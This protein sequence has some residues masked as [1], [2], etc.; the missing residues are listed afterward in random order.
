MAQHPDNFDSQGPETFLR[1]LVNAA[2][3]LQCKATGL[4]VI[5]TLSVAAVVSG[6]LLRTSEKFAREQRGSQMV[7]MASMLA[8]AAAP[9]FAA[10]DFAALRDLAAESA[11]GMPLLYVVISDLDGR[12]I[13][14][15]EDEKAG[16]LQTLSGPVA[17]RAPVPGR[18]ILR[19]GSKNVPVF[20]DVTY[21]ITT[22]ETS[23]ATVGGADRA[24]PTKLLGY[25]RTG[26]VE[27]RWQRTMASRLDLLIGVGILAAVVAIPLGFLLVRRIVSPL[28]GLADAMNRFSRGELDVRSSVTRTDEIGR[29]ALAFNR[30]ADEHQRTH[31][32]IVR[33]NADLEKRVAERTEQLRELA[34]REP[35][36]GLYNRRYFN[37]MLEH[38][39]SEAKR[40]ESDISCIMLDLDDFKNVNDRFG[41]QTGD[42]LLILTAETITR[43]LRTA[44]VAARFGGDEFIVLLPQTDSDRAHVL[45][46][47]IA[48]QLVEQVREHLAG[49]RVTVSMGIASLPSANIKNAEALIRAAD[50]A[51][52]EA[53]AAGKDRIVMASTA[54]R[55]AVS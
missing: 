35:L 22:H 17:G 8:K 31:E 49:V 20:L 46:E 19:S 32:R 26:M 28:D 14:A 37:E 11:D 6:Y 10:G 55:P 43:Q 29:L 41:H 53:K 9:V 42:K 44:D 50:N 34:S 54:A 18:P 33:L 23:G 5:L 48:E 13:A 51:L 21:P 39:F 47:R 12:Q 3:S 7:Q 15:A 2:L 36:T 40:Y 16:V 25:V 4:V 45:S 52:Y 27:D 24:T 38:R 30:M 1:R